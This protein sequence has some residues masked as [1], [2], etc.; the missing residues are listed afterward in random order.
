MEIALGSTCRSKIKG[1]EAVFNR[2]IVKTCDVAL[3]IGQPLSKKQTEEYA[4]KRAIEAQRVYPN[5]DLF[6]GIQNGIWLI[7]RPSK[8]EDVNTSQETSK[9]TPILYDNMWDGACIH[10]FGKNMQPVSIWTREVIVF[11]LFPKGNNGEWSK[12]E[13]PHIMVS[14]RPRAYYIEEAVRDYVESFFYKSIGLVN[15][16]Q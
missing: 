2:A 12:Y 8:D 13:D 15:K 7:D 1:I 11:T 14:N 16:K 4:I 5:C 3:E 9:I 6:I 10:I